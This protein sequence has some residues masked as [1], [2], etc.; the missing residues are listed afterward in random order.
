MNKP[1]YKKI[2]EH[3]DKDEIIGKLVIGVSPIDIN[4]W[5]KIK[6]TNVSEAK[7]V[8]SE[9][10]IKSFK[11]NH[12]D[13]YNDMLQDLSSTKLAVATNTQ[14]QIEL[15]VKGNPAYKDALLRVANNELNI[16]KTMAIMAINV[17]TRMAQVFDTIMDDPRNI[18]TKVDR[19]FADYAEILGNLLDKY[20]KWK[21]KPVADQVV[22]H[23][24]TLQVV[25]QHISVFHDVIKKFLSQM[26]TEASMYFLE[27]FNEEFS[28]LKPPV[29]DAGPSQEMKLAEV[30]L[31]NETINTK[32]NT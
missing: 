32:L 29:P 18:N 20:H 5:L 16:E 13:F 21:E 23:N 26:D 17:E 11:D 3:P 25:D 14:D 1:T 7:F 9:K 12:L 19:L 27:V 24:V 22:Q 2:L 15:A 30:K 6:Y 28:K 8:L 4:D 10:I 31:L